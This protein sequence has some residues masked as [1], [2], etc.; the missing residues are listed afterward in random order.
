MKKLKTSPR[1]LE[2]A[3]EIKFGL[4]K[5]SGVSVKVS[6]EDFERELEALTESLKA[7]FADKALSENP[8]IG[9]VRRLYR[10]V[11]WEPTKYRPSS[12]ALARRLL[13]GKGL[14]RINNVVDR[15]NLVSARY[16]IPMGLYDLDKVKGDIM[17]DIGG[18]GETY[19][20][21]SRPGIRATGKLVLR[22]EIGIFGNPTADSKR[23]SISADTRDVLAVFFCPAGVDEG[24]ITAML[25]ELRDAY[26][27]C[28]DNV[29]SSIEIA[30]YKK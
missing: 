9:K 10:S 23:T 24:Y 21:I 30:G 5:S 29:Q 3:G 20:G 14:Y 11:G 15:G 1:F 6:G 16:H 4:L 17:L 26:A 8:V 18:E 28:G 22:D 2:K 19:D 13:Q 27:A 25:E 12:E 7:T